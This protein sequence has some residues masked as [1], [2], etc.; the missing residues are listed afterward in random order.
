MVDTCHQKISEA[1]DSDK[2]Y[3][4]GPI[5]I[6]CSTDGRLRYL[7][8]E[9]TKIGLNSNVLEDKPVSKAQPNQSTHIPNAE[10]VPFCSSAI[11]T[12]EGA[13]PPRREASADYLD[14]DLDPASVLQTW[15]SSPRSQLDH[16]RLENDVHPPKEQQTDFSPA[17]G[18]IPVPTNNPL[19]GTALHSSSSNSPLNTSEIQKPQS[20]KKNGGKNRQTAQQLYDQRKAASK[21]LQA[22]KLGVVASELDP[23]DIYSDPIWLGGNDIVVEPPGNR[24]RELKLRLTNQKEVLAELVGNTRMEFGWY[25]KGM[26]VTIASTLLEN[27]NLEEKRDPPKRFLS[28]NGGGKWLLVQDAMLEAKEFGAM[29]RQCPRLLQI[30]DSHPYF[31]EKHFKMDVISRSIDVKLGGEMRSGS[32]FSLSLLTCGSVTSSWPDPKSDFSRHMD[33]SINRLIQTARDSGRALHKNVKP[34]ERLKNQSGTEVEANGRLAAKDYLLVKLA[35]MGAGMKKTGEASHHEGLP[36]LL[37]KFFEMLLG[38]VMIHEGHAIIDQEKKHGAQ[39]LPKVSKRGG[40]MLRDTLKQVNCASN[41]QIGSEMDD[42][43][44]KSEDWTELKQR[45]IG[46]LALILTF[47]VQGWMG[48]FKNRKKYTYRDIYLLMTLAHDMAAKGL[49]IISPQ[50]APESRHAPW[51]NLNKF[52]ADMFASSGLG[53]ENIDWYPA[54]EIWDSILDEA[55]MANYFLVDLFEEIMSPGKSLCLSNLKVLPSPTSQISDSSKDYWTK[56]IKDV[57]VACSAADKVEKD[58]QMKLDGSMYPKSPVSPH[59]W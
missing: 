29:I 19:P 32:W 24:P 49:S 27:H 18:L 57:Y 34:S 22:K 50:L 23:Y 48:C 20:V 25:A 44:E 16:I 9:S 11:V 58:K 5:D 36:D 37:Q 21:V 54:Q 43:N 31:N 26:L 4:S 1:Q 39:K 15:S 52:L 14:P 56:L 10:N 13:K 35:A 3:V 6:T 55:T 42:N 12:Q 41:G 40:A 33:N 17:P 46:A 47:G 45:S 2:A 7:K 30:S 8:C 53:Y 28:V 38:V 59:A 51:Y